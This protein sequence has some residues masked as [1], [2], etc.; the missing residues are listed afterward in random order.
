MTL[1]RREFLQF[2]AVV[3]AAP[4]VSRAAFAE[5]YPVRPVK[6]VA[7]WSLE[8]DT[9]SDLDGFGTTNCRLPIRD[10]H[11]GEPQ[12]LSPVQLRPAEQELL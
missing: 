7:G 1:R 4:A 6:I 5:N 11:A 2:V 9:E 8:S 3:A 10:E 12:S